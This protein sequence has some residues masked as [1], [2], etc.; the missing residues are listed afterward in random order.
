MDF[1]SKPIVLQ[2]FLLTR[3]IK[4]QDIKE[5]ILGPNNNWK[6]FIRILYRT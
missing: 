2:T 3:Y 1:N 6:I 4:F 5:N